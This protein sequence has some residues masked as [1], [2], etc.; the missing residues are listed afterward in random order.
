MNGSG[1]V[2]R[3]VAQV[4]DDLGPALAPVGHTELLRSITETARSLFGA[5]ACSVALLDETKTELVFYVA[6][7]A[8]AK[9]VE[10]M[11]MPADK[12]IAGWVVNSGQPMAI[13]DVRRDRRFAQDVAE[14][15]GYVPDSI[16]AMPLQTERDMLGVISVLDRTTDRENAEDDMEML[17]LF[18]QQAA[19]A[20]E[21]SLV[22][23]ELGHAL[24]AAVRSAADG[25]SF[26]DALDEVAR[27]SSGPRAELA[28]LAS[29]FKALADVGPE[30][31][32]AGTR[33]LG[34]FVRYVR[35]RSRGL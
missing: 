28:E 17:N 9:T 6:S 27:S 23:T 32:D 33:L 24:F 8:G 22:F 3:E 13:G 20:I 29:H 4:A 35:A 21:N 5:A 2:L 19:L 31:R 1:D 12:G 10:G 16:L 18:A 25:R 15:T 14:D 11:R 26:A 7:G 34:E 30:E